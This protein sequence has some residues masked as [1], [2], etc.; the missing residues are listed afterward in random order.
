MKEEA[1][2]PLPKFFIEDNVLKLESKNWKF[3]GNQKNAYIIEITLPEN[4][5]INVKMFAGVIY[6]GNLI[7]DIDIQ[8]KAGNILGN[9]S[10]KN[11]TAKIW[12]GDINLEFAS[13]T[14]DSK[15]DLKCSLGDI[16]LKLPKYNT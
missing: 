5:N 15:L 10:S 4:T 7:G 13:I 3:F 8:L 9:V 1:Q 14:K 11:V 12:A 2:H 6:L 16:K